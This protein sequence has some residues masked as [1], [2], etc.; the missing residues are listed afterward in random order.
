M[1]FF[2]VFRVF[3]GQVLLLTTKDTKDTK[4]DE[5]FFCV[6][7]VFRGQVLF[8]TTKDTKNEEIFKQRRFFMTNYAKAIIEKDAL[9]SL[10]EIVETGREVLERKL[11]ACK[12]RI[13]K[14]EEKAGMD[15]DTF[16]RR[17]ES[18]ELGDGREW[19]E[20]DHLASVARN[21]QNRMSD[22]P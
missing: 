15:T 19:M 5:I 7:R 9:A 16:G 12:N 13:K 2:C 22:S 8:L 10:Q 17:F 20:W 4:S 6:F 14:F 21:L 18:G 1:C 3:R 11:S